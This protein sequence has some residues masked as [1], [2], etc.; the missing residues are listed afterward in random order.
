MDAAA[1]KR[2]VLQVS[3]TGTPRIAFL[4]ADGKTINEFVPGKR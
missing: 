2:M 3:A 4:D 1:R